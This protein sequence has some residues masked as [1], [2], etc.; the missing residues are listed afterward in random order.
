MKA[1]FDHC[2]TVFEEMMSEATP[3][4]DHDPAAETPATGYMIWT[5]HTTQLFARLGLSTPYYTTV[6]DRLKKMGCVEQIKR[7]G[8]NALSKWRL[9]RP[10]E[11]EFFHAAERMKKPTQGSHAALE[12]QVRSLSIRLSSLE[13]QWRDFIQNSPVL[14]VHGTDSGLFEGDVS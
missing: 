7:G 4:L 2:I 11:E 1:L 12:Q 6:M 13:Q 14:S 9:V 10:P 8:G 3:E 5:G